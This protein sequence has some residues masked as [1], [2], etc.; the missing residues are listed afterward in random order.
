MSHP[1]RHQRQAAIPFD[2]ITRTVVANSKA[3]VSPVETRPRY[4]RCALTV[5]R[6]GIDAYTL[7]LAEMISKPLRGAVFRPRCGR[8]PSPPHGSR[9]A[10]EEHGVPDVGKPRRSGHAFR[11]AIEHPVPYFAGLIES[12]RF[13]LEQLPAQPG[14]E[15][16][17]VIR[18]D[19]LSGAYHECLPIG[20][21]A[22]RNVLPIGCL[23]IACQ[24]PRS[25]CPRDSRKIH[26]LARP[27]IQ[28]AIGDR[29]GGV[30]LFPKVVD[31]KNF[32][33]LPART[34]AILPVSLVK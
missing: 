11:P 13:P 26:S 2:E 12:W 10:R 4:T 20:M 17:D 16:L 27:D 6:A 19:H 32:H 7:H 25:N 30:A 8:R 9:V 29:R 24:R 33:L 14:F 18:V 28:A 22:D 15:K 23:P 3:V 5:R 21:F 31:S 34:T 1:M